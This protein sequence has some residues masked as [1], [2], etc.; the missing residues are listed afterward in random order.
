MRQEVPTW[1]AVVVIL[2]VLV[3]AGVAYWL[4]SPKPQQGVGGQLPTVTAPPPG[5][6]GAGGPMRPALPEKGK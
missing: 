2:S 5:V 6:P 4:L 1:L 3:I